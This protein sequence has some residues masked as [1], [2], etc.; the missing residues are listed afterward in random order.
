MLL[1]AE[2]DALAGGIGHAASLPD[3]PASLPVG[4]PSDLLR[5]RPDVREAERKLAQA[6]AEKAWR[7]LKLYP[8]FNLIGAPGNLASNSR[9][10]CS[11][12]PA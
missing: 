1:A 10:R 4:L 3:I 5:R 11:I 8:K 7:S 6:T 12:S 9:A 2:P